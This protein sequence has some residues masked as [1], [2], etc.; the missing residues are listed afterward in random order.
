MITEGKVRGLSIAR[1]PGGVYPIHVVYG[2]RVAVTQMMMDWMGPAG[3][4]YLCWGLK[5]GALLGVNFD[6]GAGLE[7]L[8]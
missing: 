1:L 5:R 8:A 7:Q 2:E 4:V 3:T 6:N